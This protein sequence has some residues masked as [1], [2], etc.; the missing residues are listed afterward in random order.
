MQQ[1]LESTKV[2]P[3]PVPAYRTLSE[4]PVTP[5]SDGSCWG[6][7]RRTGSSPNRAQAGHTG[8]TGLLGTGAAAL[9][10]LYF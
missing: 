8:E 9:S 1:A 5:G 3:R 10:L 4:Q 2:T 6:I 7:P